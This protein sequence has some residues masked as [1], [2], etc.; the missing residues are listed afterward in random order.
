MPTL[1]TPSA[2][3]L[4]AV[5]IAAS[6]PTPPL[7]DT[8]VPMNRRDFTQLSALTLAASGLPSFGQATLGTRPLRFAPIGLG[9]IS[10]V[11]MHACQ[12]TPKARITGLVTGH[13]A[14]KGAKFAA[15]YNVPQSSIYTY[16]TF[17]RIKD[18]PDIDAVY[19]GLPNAMHCE[20]AVRAAKAGKHVLCEKPMAISS[21]ECR[22]MI[23]ACKQANVKL[24]VAYRIHYD[25][26]WNK[27]R[28]LVRSG[29][30][31]EIQGFQG[32][33]YGP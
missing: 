28:D 18:N 5:G 15:Q 10:N 1:A 20:Y 8:L 30:L 2:P 31:G 16:E 26:T 7:R 23:D 22:T 6:C 4:A 3:G 11:F 9:T 12:E 21:A 14:D 25:P 29:A 17:D 24:M 27:L 13:P 33:F 32:G 19:I